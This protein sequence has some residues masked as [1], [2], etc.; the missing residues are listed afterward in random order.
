[1]SAII[2]QTPRPAPTA[3][4]LRVVGGN[5]RPIVTIRAGALP[6]AIAAIIRGLRAEAK[7]Y[8]RG[9]ALAR[10]LD[11]GTIVAVDAPWL[12]T[13]IEHTF[14]VL[15]LG[16]DGAAK[17][18]NIN[19]DVAQRVLAARG[20]WGLPRLGGVVRYPVMRADGSV[21]AAPG[22]DEQTEL[23]YLDDA[24]SG[25]DGVDLPRG[26]DI[27]KLRQALERVWEPFAL[28]PFDSPL[29]R[30]VFLAALLTT[31]CRPTLPTSPAFSVTA[32]AAGTGKSFIS[33][34]L[35][36]LV[37]ARRSA[38][39][40]PVDDAN[41]TEKRIF[42]K[43]LSGQPGLTLDNLTGVIDN[44]ALCAMLTSPEPEGRILGKSEIV[45]IVNRSLCVLNGNNITMGG[46]LF[47]RVLPI[48]LDANTERPETR[49]FSFDPREFIR[50]R[51]RDYRLDLLN[52]LVTFQAAGAPRIGKGSMGSFGEWERLVRQCV[53][54][55]IQR[56]AAPVELADPLDALSLSR[57]EDP[58]VAQH[59]ALME[60][61]RDKYGDD[62]VQ[63]KDLAAMADGD[64]LTSAWRDP[65]D[66]PLREVLCEIA[67][68]AGRGGGRF[69]RR[70]FAWWLRSKVG[71]VVGG[72]RIDKCR[73]DPKH[74]TTWRVSRVDDH[75]EPG[76][77]ST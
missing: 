38:L 24:G 36:Q 9:G 18:A 65:L 4:S 16:A 43:L 48:R 56:D 31:V 57:A 6:D 7:L 17:P 45:S 71:V 25:I 70:L 2:D 1:M 33:E 55:L 14:R 28:F 29:S 60:A 63:V 13:H 15:K 66:A 59:A 69:N 10:L 46:D 51:L 22:Y 49:E 42:G 73:A 20:A 11:D 75:P 64:D 34:C 35:M 52:V 30:G 53:C 8:E 12:K 62:E 37:D 5:S 54:W 40:L 39:P 47:R 76:G 74:G 23:L 32:P 3:P 61:W 19:D 27:C 68:P 50:R 67:S 72:L 58:H 44:A 41:E 26:L 77:R 21:L